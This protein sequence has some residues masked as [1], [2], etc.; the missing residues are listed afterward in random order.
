MCDPAKQIM[1]PLNHPNL[2]KFYGGV[3]SEGA[4]KL[5]LVLEYCS[6]GSLLTLM[7]GTKRLGTWADP[8]FNL[9]LGIA[10]CFKYLHHGLNDPVIHRDLKPDNVLVSED[11]Q[12][13]VADFGESRFFDEKRR[14]DSGAMTM[15][16]VGTML[17][18]PPEASVSML[19]QAP[20]QNLRHTCCPSTDLARGGLQRAS[21][22]VFFRLYFA[23]DCDRGLQVHQETSTGAVRRREQGQWWPGMAPACAEWA[24]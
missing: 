5:C 18:C 16:M 13:K 21:R 3:W 14:L 1:T 19:R 2:V 7:D 15:T 4:D 12:S 22:C 9:A 10:Q 8:R 11:L 23:R 17:Y 20:P 24:C 6:R